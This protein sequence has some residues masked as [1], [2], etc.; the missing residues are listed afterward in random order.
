MVCIETQKVNNL[1]LISCETVSKKPFN[2]K[3]GL[4]HVIGLIENKKA[5]LVL[6]AN[7]VDPIELVIFLPALCKKMVY[8]HPMIS[9][10][11]DIISLI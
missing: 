7:D 6:I 1:E 3:Y 9:H 10:W 2:V 8:I 4:N 5:S 11:A